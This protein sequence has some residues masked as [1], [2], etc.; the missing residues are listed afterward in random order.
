MKIKNKKKGNLNHGFS[1]FV[2]INIKFNLKKLLTFIM[3]K[4][5][6]QGGEGGKVTVSTSTL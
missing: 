2:P 5:K 4:K 1:Y 3:R 6:C